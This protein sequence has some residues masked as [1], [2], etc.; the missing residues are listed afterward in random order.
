[1]TTLNY[2]N[3]TTW[4]PLPLTKAVKNLSETLTN[5]SNTVIPSLAERVEI[6][7]AGAVE[8]RI[9]TTADT[10]P[11]S[12]TNTRVTIT[13]DLT[14]Y[15]LIGKV[16]GLIRGNI[17]SEAKEA[18]SVAISSVTINDVTQT[19]LGFTSSGSTSRSVQGR[20]VLFL[21]KNNSST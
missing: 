2:K 18:I 13:H 8:I 3:G 4:V 20:L 15:T 12:S 21:L 11:S 19:E 6:L 16:A 9:Y 1:M 5:L 7:E 10:S 14:G 17:S